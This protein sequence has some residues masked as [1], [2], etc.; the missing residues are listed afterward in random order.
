MTAVLD[1]MLWRLIGFCI[2]PACMCIGAYL[3]LDPKFFWALWQF[4]W[5]MLLCSPMLQEAMD[6]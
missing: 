3:Y 4:A 1:A 5:C 6:E 2:T